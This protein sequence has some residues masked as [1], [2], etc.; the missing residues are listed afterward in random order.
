[1]SKYR[2]I[3][4]ENWDRKEQFLFFRDYDNP[5]FGL[6]TN[7]DVTKLLAYTQA[8]NYSFFAAYLFASQQQIHSIPEFRYRIE[9]DQVIE[10]AVV[11]AG[12]TV[13]KENDVFTFC[14]FDHLPSFQDFNAHVTAQIEACRK[15]IVKLIDHD[16]DQA[17]IHYS[18]I[19]WVHFTGLSHPRNYKTDDS[20]PKIVFGKYEKQA[21]KIMMPV[22]VEAH[23]ALLDGFHMG[24]YFKRFQDSIND[25]ETL[26]EG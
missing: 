19:P 6:T 9:D 1:M 4:I 25:P 12:S 18:V 21:G 16:D 17:Q 8:N 3:D 2:V 20:I 22:S 7:L 15:P 13:L 14:Y 11:S 24:L 26:L 5:F 23:H 10:Y